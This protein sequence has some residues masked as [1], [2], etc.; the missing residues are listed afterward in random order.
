MDQIAVGNCQHFI[1]AV[2][3]K[4]N[5]LVEHVVDVVNSCRPDTGHFAVSGVESGL[6]V[7]SHH[8]GAVFLPDT[9]GVG[10]RK[11]SCGVAGVAASPFFVEIRHGFDAVDHKQLFAVF[12]VEPQFA[13]GFSCGN[14]VFGGE[15]HHFEIQ[16]GK[17]LLFHKE[18]LALCIKSAVDGVVPVI[19]SG[20]DL[21]HLVGS[22]DKGLCGKDLHR[23]QGHFSVAQM[24][25]GTE[26]RGKSE[27]TPL[28]F[29]QLNVGEP[30]VTELDIAVVVSPDTTVPLGIFEFKTV[31]LFAVSRVFKPGRHGL[32]GGKSPHILHFSN[33]AEICD[34]L[35][36]PVAVVYFREGENIFAPHLFEA[37]FLLNFFPG[38]RCLGVR[39]NFHGSKI[40]PAK[41]HY[42]FVF[43]GRDFPV[44]R[45]AAVT[46][47][48]GEEPCHIGGL[49]GDIHN[50]AV[51]LEIFQVA[52]DDLVG[53]DLNET[54]IG[55]HDDTHHFAFFGK[56]QFTVAAVVD[57]GVLFHL[58]QS[59][60]GDFL[61]LVEFAVEGEE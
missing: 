2:A 31:I 9:D 60:C 61:P 18:C 4:V 16:G 14:A 40:F 50:C 41:L 28:E 8:D 12:V 17:L 30:L 20:V 13:V 10:R 58:E 38:C 55:K 56:E 36:Y 53:G 34:V 44:S 21:D 37:V 19:T 51:D 45:F 33:S 26:R 24:E 5:S 52:A 47:G 6:S 25:S 46:V 3:V 15:V 1:F 59:R 57:F 27:I 35:Q 43:G 7:A 39:R 29:G 49:R 11:S 54:V 42:F 23:A 48:C 22:K 32:L